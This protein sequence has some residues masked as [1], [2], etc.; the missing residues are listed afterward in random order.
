VK[1]LEN[2]MVDHKPGLE[3]VVFNA[4]QC[5]QDSAEVPHC[6]VRVQ[7]KRDLQPVGLELQQEKESC[8]EKQVI[9][10]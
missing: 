4:L 6:Q 3:M 5:S 10:G 7:Q 1:Q 2:V 8:Q 9:N